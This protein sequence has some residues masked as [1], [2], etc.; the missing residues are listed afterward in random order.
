M[1]GGSG[2][3]GE[4]GGLATRESFDG[5][6]Q[7]LA[8]F[9]EEVTLCCGFCCSG[10]FLELGFECSELFLEEVTLCCCSGYRDCCEIA[11]FFEEVTLSCCGSPQQ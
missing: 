4:G 6:E 11:L 5:L 10:C 3:G 8:L 9:F 1:L 7:V 2:C